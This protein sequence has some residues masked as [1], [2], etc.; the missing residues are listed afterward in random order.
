MK[1]LTIGNYKLDAPMVQAALS[2]YSDLAM[3]KLAREYGCPYTINEVVLDKMVAEGGKKMRRM[4]AT[5]E[6]ERPVAGQLMGSEPDQFAAAA[7]TLVNMGYNVID[8]N[9][10]CPVK[11]VLG[12][13][14]GGFLLSDP[15]T[16]R[17]I[18]TAVRD[19]VNGRTPLTL[20]MRR[21]MDDSD[22]SER[23]FFE[24]L[25]TAYELGYCS[26]TVHGRTVQQRYVGPSRWAFLTRLKRHIGDRQL[27]GSGDL[28]SA[29]DCKRMM[30]ETGV[31]GVSIARGAIGNPFIFNEL[32]SLLTTGELP[33]PATLTEQRR[34]ITRHFELICDLWG[35]ERGSVI[36]RKFGVRYAE[37]HPLYEQVKMAYVAV[38]TPAALQALLAEWYDE[39]AGFPPVERRLRPEALVAA[40]ATL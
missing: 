26:I 25:E 13:C 18:L 4:L 20:K 31:D 5:D 8:V 17:D 10:G 24:I 3:R 29:T 37:L 39:K 40:G 21:G 36:F 1:T 11:K 14:R 30:D 35:P 38:R 6:D 16:A 19:A 9:F 27:L 28:F 2:G 32:R 12:R 22:E 33:P 23:N 34:A 15:S 7:D